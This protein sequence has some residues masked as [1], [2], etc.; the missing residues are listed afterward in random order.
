MSK[1]KTP[2]KKIELPRMGPEAYWM[3]R[4]RHLTREVERAEE[5]LDAAY[6]LLKAAML[7]L[8]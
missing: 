3:E 8:K 2:T 1:K 4:A 6:D 5:K 7:I